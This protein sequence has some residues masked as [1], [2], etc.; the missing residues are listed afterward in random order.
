MFSLHKIQVRQ[1]LYLRFMFRFVVVQLAHNHNRIWLKPIQTFSFRLWIQLSLFF[2]LLC[3]VLMFLILN[4]WR[5]RHRSLKVQCVIVQKP[6]YYS[7]QYLCLQWVRVRVLSLNLNK[8][9]RL[10]SLLFSKHQFLF[11]HKLIESVQ[12]RLYFSLIIVFNSLMLMFIVLR[13]D[14]FSF[15]RSDNNIGPMLTTMK[16]AMTN[17]KVNNQILSILWTQQQLQF[18][19]LIQSIF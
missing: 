19:I 8:W 17:P 4:A 9:M 7:R 18:R 3:K 13:V 1:S 14:L 16:M 2:F 10:N 12:L 6:L 5:L 11:L 15:Y